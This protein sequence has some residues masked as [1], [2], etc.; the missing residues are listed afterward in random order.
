MNSMAISSNTLTNGIT[1]AIPGQPVPFA[2]AGGGRTRARF[3][4]PKQRAHMTIIGIYA[5]RA[6]AGRDLFEGPVQLTVDASWPWP[7]VRPKSHW[8]TARP[9]LDNTVKLLKDS[10]NDICWKDDSQVC[11]L[12]AQKFYSDTPELRIWIDPL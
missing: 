2:R 3:T 4:P 6:M 1:F 12:V 10:L 5:R 8:R 11:A 7:K 9:D